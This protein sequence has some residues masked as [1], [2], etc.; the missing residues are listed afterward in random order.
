MACFLWRSAAVSLW[1]SVLVFSGNHASLIE[2]RVGVKYNRHQWTWIQRQVSLARLRLGTIQKD[3]LQ[4]QTP[5][6]PG[7]RF[8][9]ITL[10]FSNV[11][12]IRTLPGFSRIENQ[13]EIPHLKR[14]QSVAL[15][16]N[17]F[18]VRIST[19]QLSAMSGS[20]CWNRNAHSVAHG[21]NQASV[22]E[23]HRIAHA[24]SDKTT[25]DAYFIFPVLP[26]KQF[27]LRASRARRNG[28]RSSIFKPNWRLKAFWN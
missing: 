24:I 12:V 7:A 6:E 26:E 4:S 25:A 21:P 3:N 9:W 18:W 22:L 8:V 17:I 13:K 2:R 16:V 28:E 15:Y 19:K 10:L 23:I 20:C 27:P 14:L 11:E 5:F 1:G